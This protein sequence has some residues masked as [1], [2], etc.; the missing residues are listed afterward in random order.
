MVCKAI[1]Y[2]SRR[3]PFLKKERKVSQEPQSELAVMYTFTTEEEVVVWQEMIFQPLYTY[4]NMPQ[5]TTTKKTNK[6]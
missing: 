5:P 3:R 4:V 6:T 2:S 1:E